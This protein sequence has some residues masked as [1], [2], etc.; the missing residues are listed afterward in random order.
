MQLILGV[1]AYEKAILA[2]ERRDQ[3]NNYAI[4]KTDM[5]TMH[6]MNEKSETISIKPYTNPMAHMNPRIYDLVTALLMS[7]RQ[8]EIRKMTIDLA[9]IHTG[10]Q[11]LEVGC[12]TGSLTI[13]AKKQTGPNGLVVGIDPLPQMIARAQKKAKDKKLD[14]QFQIAPYELIPFP[15]GNFDVVLASFMIFHTDDALRKQGLN[16][17]YR[18]L[19]PGGKFLIVDTIPIQK[20][21]VQK[22]AV[23]LTNPVMWENPLEKLHPMLTQAGFQSIQIGETKYSIIGYVKAIK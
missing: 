1:E 2:I 7:G 14:I 17:V 4:L 20:K 22:I 18:I 6:N 12:G 23:D 5:N 16:E 15:D 21:N 19:R 13:Y 10:D 8:N 3:E 11:V 9:D